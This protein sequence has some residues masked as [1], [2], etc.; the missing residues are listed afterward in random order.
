MLEG[1][2][3]LR[4]VWECVPRVQKF[5]ARLAPKVKVEA[6]ASRDVS[7]EALQ[8]LNRPG[9]ER[10]IAELARAGRMREARLETRLHFAYD[11]EQTERFIERLLRDPSGE[12]RRETA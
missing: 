9:L 8:E 5:V 3:R 1:T 12:A 7:V 4:I 11:S 10:R 2:S 6:T